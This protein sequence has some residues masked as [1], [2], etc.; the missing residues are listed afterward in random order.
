LVAHHQGAD[1]TGAVLEADFERPDV[2]DDL[3]RPV[4]QQHLAL[5]QLLDLELVAHMLRDAQ[6]QGP[7][8]GER[9]YLQLQAGIARVAQKDRAHDKSHD[10]GPGS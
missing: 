10:V 1:E 5:R 4:G 3:P 9:I 6:V 7:G 8:V 2:R